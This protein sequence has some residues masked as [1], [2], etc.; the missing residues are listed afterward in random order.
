MKEGNDHLNLGLSNKD[1]NDHLFG[2]EVGKELRKVIEE[3]FKITDKEIDLLTY[4]LKDSY[5][6]EVQV[7]L[8]I[9]SLLKSILGKRFELETFVDRM[10]LIKGEDELKLYLKFSKISEELT[11]SYETLRLRIYTD[12]YENRVPPFLPSALAH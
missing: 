9:L 4:L 12:T 11:T 6:G 10:V 2:N 8:K 1:N 5:Q 3:Y 7:K